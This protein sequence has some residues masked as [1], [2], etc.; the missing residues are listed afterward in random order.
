MTKNQEYG[1]SIGGPIR[2]DQIWFFG[3]IRWFDLAQ[4]QPDFPAK[5]PTIDDRQGFIKVTAQL[6][7]RTKIQGS[8]TQRDFR[9]DPGNASFAT[10]NNPENWNVSIRPWRIGFLGVTQ[11]ISDR[12]YLEGRYSINTARF[13]TE[14]ASTE[15]GFIDLTTGIQ[16]GGRTG[17]SGPYQHRDT[18]DI[19]GSLT[20]FRERWLGGSHNIRFGYENVHVPFQW[21]REVPG[22]LVHLLQNGR[23]FRVRLYNTPIRKQANTVSRHAA[24]I[25]DEWTIKARYT[26]NVGVRV[27]STE[28]WFPEQEG[29]GGRWFPVTVFPEERIQIKWLTAAPRLGMVW[30]VRGDRRVSVKGSF[31]RYYEALNVQHVFNS[32]R[33]AAAFQEW[34]WIDD[35]GDRFFQNGEQGRLIQDLRAN[36]DGFDPDLRQPYVDEVVGGVDWQLG[37]EW[38]L[39]FTG[40]YKRERDIMENV[41][42]GRPFSAYNPLQVVNPLNGQPMTIYA[43][44]R[45]YLGAQRIALLTTPK[46]PV[47]LYRD[48]KGLEVIA[49]RRMKDGWAFQSAL[50]LSRSYGNIGNAFGSTHGSSFLYDDPNTLINIEG[51]LDL[52]APFQLKLQG[53]YLAPYGIAVSAFYTAISGFPIKPPE[54]FPRDVLGAYTL[55]FTRADNPNI[56]VESFVDVA[57][58]PRGTH[59]IDFR[60]KLSLRAEKQFEW[61][62]RWKLGLVADFFNLFNI[63]TVTAVQTMRFGHA[64]F[65]K[66][67]IIERPR[68]LRL[69]IRL[70]F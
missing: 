33:N 12:T 62:E 40:I 28:G 30:D 63:N 19:R 6:S 46:N 58:E 2:K 25:Q 48:Y 31:A 23:A 14:W 4:S 22:D 66:P 42:I 37:T 24:F 68:A 67:A 29:G 13:D 43:L 34:E 15:S 69:G 45:S 56:V 17:P 5:D 70:S 16:S 52:D 8:Y 18:R 3:D 36:L 47:A 49:N 26:L 11:V 9:L 51:P 55:R 27:E 1:F 32:N 59:R 53:T 10:N 50:N 20:H 39:S 61:N 41:D 57:G 7:S 65:L 35:N 64:N 44:D 54:G 60:H 21:S 38:L